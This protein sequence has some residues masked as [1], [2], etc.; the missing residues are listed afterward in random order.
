M[1]FFFLVRDNKIALNLD[2]NKTSLH[3]GVPN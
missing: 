2:D 1:I 3:F